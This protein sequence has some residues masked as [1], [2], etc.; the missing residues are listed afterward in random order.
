MDGE[1][2]AREIRELLTATARAARGS[3]PVLQSLHG[4]IE[5]ALVTGATGNA[6]TDDGLSGL[7]E[8]VL[9]DLNSAAESARFLQKE[10]DALWRG[11]PR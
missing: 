11:A 2:E 3:V 6:D 7:A 9:D 4:R 8:D 5:R 1:S 10:L